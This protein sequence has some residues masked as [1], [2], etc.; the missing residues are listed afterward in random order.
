MS[1]CV[2]VLQQLY[3]SLKSILEFEGTEQEFEDTFMLTFQI[4]L[5]DTFE[6]ISNFNLKEDGDKIP[7]TLE[8]R[9]EFVELYAD[10]ILNKGIDNSFRAFKRGF[11]KITI[12]SPLT[13]CYFP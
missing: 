13:S 5:T 7:V 10:F 3:Q 11:M 1:V 4:G 8:T 6:S 9:K 2:C 12:N